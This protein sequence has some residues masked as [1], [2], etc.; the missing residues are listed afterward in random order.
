MKLADNIRALRKARALTQEQLAE[1]LGVTVGAV[2]KWESGRSAP[3]V[4]LLMEM[5]DLFGVSVDGLL[6]FTLHSGELQQVQEQLRSL[7]QRKEYTDA[8][9]IA[10]RALKRYPND[11]GIVYWSAAMYQH[12]G[13]E[14]GNRRALE[15]ALELL[16]RAVLLLPQNTD[17]E[18][19]ETGIRY[20]MA[21]CH[22]ALGDQETCIAILKQFNVCGVHNPTIG[23]TYAASGQY[24]PEEALP[25]LTKAF[26][27]SIQDLLQTMGG[28]INVALR[29]KDDAAAMEA[30][31]WLLGYLRSVRAEEAETAFA[32]KL[33]ATYLAM[34]ALLLSRLER[35]AEAEA[36]IREARLL[37]E[38]FDACPSYCYNTMKFCECS[39]EKVSL[40]DDLGQ[41]AVEAVENVLYGKELGLYS[42]DVA[43]LWESGKGREE[44]A[45]D[46]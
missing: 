31:D 18:I 13:L 44:N 34:A 38:K 6:G 42:P 40:Y 16:E 8:G 24:A 23:M 30:L 26:L 32:D 27:Q 1:A 29:R 12:W 22:Q 20:Q 15:T 17:G 4:K 10:E 11:F 25:Y 14:R 46:G 35:K 2:Y 9:Q 21:I 28:Y 33:L 36:A 5:A 45:T 37:A 41:T 39:L 3:E 7:I 43:A 19:S